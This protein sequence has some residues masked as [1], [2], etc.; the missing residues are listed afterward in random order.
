VVKFQ[1]FERQDEHLAAGDVAAEVSRNVN[2]RAQ[3]RA[4]AAQVGVRCT[5][6]A[7]MILGEFK[8]KSA[9]LPHVRAGPLIPP[10]SIGS[11]EGG[12]AQWAETRFAVIVPLNVIKGV[13]LSLNSVPLSGEPA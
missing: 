8:S 1:L 6:A 2:F 12:K 7:R 4:R 9:A 13:P 11:T 10:Y 3:V 5:D